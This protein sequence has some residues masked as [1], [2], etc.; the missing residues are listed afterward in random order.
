MFEDSY[1]PS[2]QSSGCGSRF[3]LSICSNKSS[4]GRV[5]YGARPRLNTSQQVTPNDH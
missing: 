1:M 5:G 4:L 2:L 3:P